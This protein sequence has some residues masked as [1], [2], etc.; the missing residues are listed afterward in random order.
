[1]NATREKR[2]GLTLL[3]VIVAMAIFLLSMGALWQL[4]A[5]G[6]ERA[7]DVKVQS[8]ASMRCQ[9][10]LDEAMVGAQPLSSSG[11]ANFTEDEG[12]T[13]LQ[14]KIDATPSQSG[15]TGLWDVTVSVKADL[16][17]GRVIE[18]Q[19]TRMMMDPTT[20]GSTMD[21]PAAL[22][23]PNPT[24]DQPSTS[25]SGSGSSGG[26]TSGAGGGGMGGGGTGKTGGTM[27]G[28]NT[29]K[30]GGNTGN[31]G[32][33]GGGTGTGGGAGTGGGTGTG[34]TGTGT[35]GGGGA[36]G[37]GG[38]AGGGGGAAGGGTRTGG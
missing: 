9:S 8:R 37:G 31:T 38:A 5:V 20:R 29:G 32:G 1:M 2:A 27:G 26:G 7:L 15:A 10:K 11:Y 33:R 21:I 17:S 24:Q 22:P 13:N 6:T 18:S 35:G 28:G 23:P 3:E 36:T 19:L 25:G 12:D 4:V 30:T 34:G 14:W 16:P